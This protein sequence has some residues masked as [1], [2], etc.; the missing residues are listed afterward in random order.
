MQRPIE[1]VGAVTPD[2]ADDTRADRITDDRDTVGVDDRDTVGVEDAAADAAASGAEGTA[3]RLRS[4]DF[5]GTD[6]WANEA[7]TDSD[8]DVVGREDARA[9]AAASGADPDE[10]GH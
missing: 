8:T 4:D 9:D 10:V 1:G 5:A 6:R 3:D 7:V 2:I